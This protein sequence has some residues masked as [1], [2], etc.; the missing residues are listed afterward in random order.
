MQIF[1]KTFNGQTITFN[2]NPSDSLEC[3]KDQVF[4]DLRV[5]AEIELFAYREINK[6]LESQV[7]AQQPVIN[8]GWGENGNYGN[9]GVKCNANDVSIPVKLI[10]RESICRA[11]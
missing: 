3:F 2:A 6:T 5:N 11:L 8:N 7:A 9:Y 4:D 1:V 10:H